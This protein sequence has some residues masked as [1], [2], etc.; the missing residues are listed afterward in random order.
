M[1]LLCCY[2]FLVSCSQFG[3]LPTGERLAAMQNSPNYDKDKATFLNLYSHPPTKHWRKKAKS[4]FMRRFIN[5]DGL[6]PDY[7]LPEGDSQL[8]RF[9][10]A[11]SKAKTIWLGHSTVLLNINGKT[12]LFDPVFSDHASPVPIIVKRFQPPALSLQA[13]PPID[14]IVISHDHY[15]HLDKETIR[16]FVDQKAIRFLVPLGVGEHLVYWGVEPERI[17]AMDW[18]EEYWA[19]GLRFVAT[20]SHHFSGRTPWA[21]DKTLW[22]SWVVASEQQRIYFSGDSGYSEHFKQIGD[23]L[24]PFTLAYLD[25]G[26]YNE[27]WAQAHLLPRYFAQAFKDLRAEW[28]F[29]IHWS[30][31][32][33]SVHSWHEPAEKLQ[34]EA[35]AGNI[36]LITPKLG[37]MVVIGDGYESQ[38]WWR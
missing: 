21:K 38:T 23:R 17:K 24:G 15:D 11:D 2:L 34:H 30:M 13:L 26:Q 7:L 16:F 28:Y 35:D 27:R 14:Y 12:I 25:S 32:C 8:Q 37:E 19:D 9:S 36:N 1:R 5:T 3:R 6:R 31:F 29:P 20:P 4:W 22:A 18:W 33:L 10:L